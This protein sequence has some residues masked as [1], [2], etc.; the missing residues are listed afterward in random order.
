[1]EGLSAVGKDFSPPFA[2]CGKFTRK[3]SDKSE[4]LDWRASPYTPI[5]LPH[6]PDSG[7]VAVMIA[8]TMPPFI[9][10]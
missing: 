5:L 2:G 8:A 9:A 10:F 6:N 7:P 3:T 1:M 4:R